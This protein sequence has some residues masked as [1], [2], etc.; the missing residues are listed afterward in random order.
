MNNAASLCRLG[1]SVATS[2]GSVEAALDRHTNV[3][4][5]TLSNKATVLCERCQKR[6]AT[7]HLTTVVVGT[8]SMTHH[9]FCESCAVDPKG[10]ALSP[11]DLETGSG[12]TSYDAPEEPD[13]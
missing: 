10:G 3:G 11:R 2:F 9:D 4:Q 13:K 7:V 1:P 12:R 5:L 6:K 8:D